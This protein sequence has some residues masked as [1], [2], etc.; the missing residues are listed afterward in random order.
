MNTDLDIVIRTVVGESRGEPF[1][2]KK[3]V[4]HVIYNRFKTKYRRRTSLSSVCLDPMQFSCWNVNDPNEKVIRNIDILHKDYL[5]C[6]RAVIEAIQDNIKGVDP[7]KGSR[8][9][10]TKAVAPKWSKGQ[11]PIY[12]VDDHVFYNTVK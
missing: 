12:E 4:T 2:D 1:E 3:A 8:H 5:E 7:T 6:A 11:I 9:Y 10:H